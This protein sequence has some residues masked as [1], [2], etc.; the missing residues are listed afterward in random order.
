MDIVRLN[1]WLSKT[2]P[3][4]KANDDAPAP[5]NLDTVQQC[6]SMRNHPRREAARRLLER[7]ARPTPARVRELYGMFVQ[8]SDMR[9]IDGVVGLKRMT[10][11]LIRDGAALFGWQLAPY[12]AAAIARLDLAQL[13]PGNFA[14]E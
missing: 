1:A 13:H 10:P 6:A 11:T 8:L 7:A 9:D 3:G 4:G 14:V 12:E 2:V 5:T